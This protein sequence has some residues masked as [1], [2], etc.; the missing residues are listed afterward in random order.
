MG[1]FG[2]RVSINRIS[3]FDRCTRS[4]EHTDTTRPGVISSSSSSSQ[5][6]GRKPVFLT[7]LF[8]FALGSAL[9]GAAKDMSFLIGSRSKPHLH[10]CVALLF[11]SATMAH[12]V[13]AAI[14]CAGDWR[15]RYRFVDADH[16]F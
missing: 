5:V 10:F 2:I 4:G 16:H 14:S 13:T 7:Q 9:C 12:T 3:S 11:A 15:R 8:L 1:W 6:F